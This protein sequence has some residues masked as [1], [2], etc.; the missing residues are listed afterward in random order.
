M[1]RTRGVTRPVPYDP[2][3]APPYTPPVDEDPFR[4]VPRTEPQ[5]DRSITLSGVTGNVPLFYGKHQLGGEILF[6][7]RDAIDD[8]LWL[9]IGLGLG[10]TDGEWGELLINDRVASS[11]TSSY[12]SYWYYRG[13]PG[14]TANAP[15]AARLASW[16]ETLAGITYSIVYLRGFTRLWNGTLPKFRFRAR[17]RRCIDPRNLAGPI[18]YSENLWVQEYDYRRAA[19]GQALPEAAIATADWA[20]AAN[21]AD[22]VLGDGSK[23][24]EYH[25]LIHDGA[26]VDDWLAEF[27]IAGHGY[28]WHDGEQYRLFLDRPATPSKTVT[29]SDLVRQ[30]YSFTRAND[31]FEKPNQVRVYFTDESD[32]FNPNA[33][34]EVS[35]TAVTLGS[36]D[37]ITVTHKL[38]GVHRRGQARRQCIFLLNNLVFDGKLQRLERATAV[39]REPGDVV[40]IELAAKGIDQAFR[41]IPVTRNPDHSYDVEYLEYNAARYSDTTVA[42]SSKIKSSFGDPENPVGPETP[43][44]VAR[45][46]GGVNQDRIILFWPAVG[47][48]DVKYE[49]RR[50]TV[51]STWESAAYIDQVSSLSTDDVPPFGRIWR[52]FVKAVSRSGLLSANAATVDVLLTSVGPE[53]PRPESQMILRVHPD[54]ANTTRTGDLVIGQGNLTVIGE[55]SYALA[56]ADPYEDRPYVKTLGTFYRSRP[57]ILLSRLASTEDFDAE[58][59]AGGY[60]SIEEWEAAVDEPRRGGAPIWAPLPDN[61]WG[62]IVRTE[63]PWD[64]FELFGWNAKANCAFFGRLEKIE[65]GLCSTEQ[66][67]E[68]RAGDSAFAEALLV[69]IDKVSGGAGPNY[70]E[71]YHEPGLTTPAD[72]TSALLGVELTTN[73]PFYQEM[74]RGVDP[75][76]VIIPALDTTWGSPPA[77]ESFPEESIQG[78]HQAVAWIRETHVRNLVTQIRTTTNGSGIFDFDVSDYWSQVFSGTPDTTWFEFKVE[79]ESTS[80]IL[81]TIQHQANYPTDLKILRVRT[82]AAATGAAAPNVQITFSMFDAG[83]VPLGFFGILSDPA[84][85]SQSV[86]TTHTLVQDVTPYMVGW[87]DTADNR[88]YEHPFTNVTN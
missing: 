77:A 56:D 22:E 32:G 62:R 27:A 49:I 61:A 29:D 66:V 15:L 45:L 87:R 41:A 21:V 73:S 68:R 58:I 53:K 20:A 13:A 9:V 3:P 51:G 26:S 19:A 36:E 79:V 1:A 23:R 6:V 54:T 14:Q 78:V 55:W 46:Y 43:Q 47:T 71:V 35:T 85:H 57:E 28:S 44:D 12:M 8:G 34:E 86:F 84:T 67:G 72:V 42:D 76:P 24:F 80:G 64:T 10:E 7:H 74:V 59:L 83:R 82:F 25:P 70:G 5:R 39:D 2:P 63:D 37:P 38:Y 69:D 75:D 40:T 17:G 50:G 65:F 33:F 60:A 4:P 52:Y 30:G 88:I 48:P 81:A 31:P 11:W 16:T 18:A